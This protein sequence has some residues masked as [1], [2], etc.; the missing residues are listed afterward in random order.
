MKCFKKT[1]SV[2]LVIFIIFSAVV[3]PNMT[4][5]SASEYTLVTAVDGIGGTVTPSGSVV[6]AARKS[7]TCN[8]IPDEG[9]VIDKITVDGRDIAPTNEYTFKEFLSDHTLNVSFSERNKGDMNGD[10]LNTSD[11]LSLLKK[12]V[13]FDNEYSEIADMNG[14]GKVDIVDIVSLKSRPYDILSDKF[15]S[16]NWKISDD[17]GTAVISNSSSTYSFDTTESTVD[18]AYYN[19]INASDWTDYQVSARFLY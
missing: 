18:S 8:I 11:D 1:I 4:A 17:S 7:V 2:C 13:L 3:L 10:G 9:Y 12:S 19:S 16:S 6:I 5:S 15:D 14:N